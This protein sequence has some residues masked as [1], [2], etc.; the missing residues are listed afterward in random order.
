MGGVAK[1]GLFE[2]NKLASVSAEG[3][4]RISSPPTSLP[5]RREQGGPQLSWNGNSQ[6]CSLRINFVVCV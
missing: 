2:N 3:L 4:N 1:C 6:I 5:S